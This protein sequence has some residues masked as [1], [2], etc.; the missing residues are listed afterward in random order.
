MIKNILPFVLA[1]I[2]LGGTHY[3]LA[4]LLPQYNLH[5]YF[6]KTQVILFLLFTKSHLLGL[7]L[8]T[9]FKVLPG[10]IFLGFSVFK[11]LFAGSYILILKRFGTYDVSKPFILIFMAC[12][13]A[14]LSIDV[15]L[16]IKEAKLQDNNTLS[17]NS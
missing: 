13:F 10:Q 3:S 7:F 1:S 4:V 17:G 2:V 16:M 5:D 15:W 6:I 8:S 9:K 11:L 12:Y 14:Y